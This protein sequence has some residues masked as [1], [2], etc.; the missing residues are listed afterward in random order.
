MCLAGDTL[1]ENASNCRESVEMC[2]QMPGGESVSNPSD[3]T[4]TGMKLPQQRILKPVRDEL[5][6][7]AHRNNP[8]KPES[9]L[10]CGNPLFWLQVPPDAPKELTVYTPD[11]YLP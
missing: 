6:A 10:L 2:M 8:R 1:F 3:V 4:V 5:I 11:E 9:E 7:A